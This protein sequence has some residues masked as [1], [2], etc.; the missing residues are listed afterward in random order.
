VP[1]ADVFA[2]EVVATAQVGA[3]PRTTPHTVTPA[4]TWA[5]DAPPQSNV[6]FALHACC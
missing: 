2:L 5:H 1:A 6:P 4:H 3:T